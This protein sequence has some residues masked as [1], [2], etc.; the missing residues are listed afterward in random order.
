MLALSRS[1]RPAEALRAYQSA[2]DVLGEELGLE[3]SERAARARGRDPSARRERRTARV[4]CRAGATEDQPS[5]AADDD[6][7]SPIR[8]RRGEPCV[9]GSI[10]SSRSSARAAWGSRG[11]RSKRHEGGS[12]SGA[13]S[14]YG[15]SSSPKSTRAEDVPPRSWLRSICLEPAPSAADTRRLIEYLGAHRALVVLDNCEHLVAAAARLAQDLLESCPTL[16]ICA[17]SREGLAVPSEVLLPVPPLALDDAVVLF[18]ERG[19][20]ADPTSDIGDESPRMQ[21]DARGALHATRRSAAR[22]RARRRAAPR[23][24]DRRARDRPRRSLPHAQPRGAHRA[25]PATDAAG[26][27]RLELRPPVRRRTAGLRSAVGLPRQLQ[28]GR[29]ACRVRRRRHLGRRRRRADRPTR[30]QVARH[31]RDGSKLEGYTRC[32]MLQTL[33]DYGRDRLEESGDAAR[34]CTTPTFATTRLLGAQRRRAARREATRL[35]ARGNREPRE[36]ARRARRRRSATATPRPRI[37]SRAASAGTGGSPVAPSKVRS[38]SP[39]RAR[40]QGP[41]K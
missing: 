6:D 23:D 29:G 16:R 14:R 20:A 21:N 36:P 4:G 22:D 33:V 32:H 18:V 34:A 7:R 1:G 30:R 39:L 12:R 37:A 15:S 2:R 41:F 31:R 9:A 8:P 13:T 5:H 10:G 24:V 40:V 38:G 3:P 17:T 27:R 28:P 19:R 11:S 25:A 35:A 26:G